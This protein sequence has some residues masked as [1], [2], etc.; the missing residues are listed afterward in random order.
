MQAML[1]GVKRLGDLIVGDRIAFKANQLDNWHQN[2]SKPHL[3]LTSS[4]INIDTLDSGKRQLTTASGK[5]KIYPNSMI[6]EVAGPDYDGKAFQTQYVVNVPE[7]F[8]GISI[9]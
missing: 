1:L 5:L 7:K 8:N 2:Y 3:K 6:F 9:E 4:V